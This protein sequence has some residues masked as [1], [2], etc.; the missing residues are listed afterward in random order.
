MPGPADMC[1]SPRKACNV[2]QTDF[3]R[4]VIPS[5]TQD[6]LCE[7]EGDEVTKV[8]GL[9]GGATSSVEEERLLLFTCIQ[10]T[11]HVTVGGKMSR[12]MCEGGTG[13]DIPAQ[14]GGRRKCLCAESDVASAL[15]RPQSSSAGPGRCAGS[16]TVLR[17]R[18]K[19]RG[20]S[21]GGHMKQVTNSRDMKHHFVAPS[22]PEQR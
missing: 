2:Y 7:E 9:R 1:K 17:G 4:K 20:L 10:D 16:Q 19:V 5:W 18:Q 8:H 22:N 12:C 14:T 15:S 13:I 6:V 3:P 21:N 11:M